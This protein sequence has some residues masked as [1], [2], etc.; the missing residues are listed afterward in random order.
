MTQP[1]SLVTRVFKARYFLSVLFWRLEGVDQILSYVWSIIREAQGFLQDDTRWRVNG[2]GRNWGDPWLPDS[3][4]PYIST[5]NPGYFDNPCVRS[6]F[7]ANTTLWDVDLVRDMFCHWD[8]SLIL[9]LPTPASY[10]VDAL[11]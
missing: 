11:F 3:N 9:S 4:D 7:H 10:M 8:V 2:N 6:L 1:N 5:P